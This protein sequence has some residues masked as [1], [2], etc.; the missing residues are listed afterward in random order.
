MKQPRNFVATQ[1]KC[2]YMIW[3]GFVLFHPSICESMNY[4]QQ[5][6]QLD[7]GTPFW[8]IEKRKT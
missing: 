2:S 7:I 3:Y 1:Q 4:V 6:E 8:N 5:N